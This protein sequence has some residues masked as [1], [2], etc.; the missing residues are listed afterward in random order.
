MKKQLGIAM[1]LMLPAMAFAHPG[2][3]MES[4]Q[5]G[6]LH[7][8]T[9]WDHLLVMLA[10][11]LWAGRL[12]GSARWQLP[13]VFMLLMAIG[14]A[15]GLAGLAFDG[16]ETAIAATVMAMGLLLLISLPI[17]PVLRMAT[18]ALFA[19]MH[20]LAHGTELSPHSGAYA[21]AGMLMATG[22]LHMA[23]LALGSQT[24][25]IAKWAQAGIA[26][27]ILLAGGYLLLA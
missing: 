24:S 23:G 27:G 26:W 20:G 14:A 18:V 16:V 7:P 13:L 21:L 9:G 25:R 4:A 15:C 2:H 17:P 12:G 5:A 8:F 10:V 22:I 11:G 19:F 1:A 3:G 6:F